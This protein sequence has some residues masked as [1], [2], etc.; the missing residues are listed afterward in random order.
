MVK[1]IKIVSKLE[2][3]LIVVVSNQGIYKI[4]SLYKLNRHLGIVILTYQAVSGVSNPIP[5]V[6]YTS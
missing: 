1:G 3:V 2:K 4:E 5:M 6:L